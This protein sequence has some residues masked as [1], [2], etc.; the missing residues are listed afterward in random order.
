MTLIKI[1]LLNK[2]K[3]TKIFSLKHHVNS[4]LWKNERG[5]EGK[6]EGEKL[7]SSWNQNQQLAPEWH[8]Q[9]VAEMQGM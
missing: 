7:G 9:P 2:L 1:Q 8:Q 3:Y 5:Q 4:D 6:R